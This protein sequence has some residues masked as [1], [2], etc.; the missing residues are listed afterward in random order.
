MLGLY[1]GHPRAK[2]WR[3]M[4]SDPVELKRNDPELLLRVLDVVEDRIA[5][6]AEIGL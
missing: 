5:Q 6:V 2:L 3:R 1:H 4:L